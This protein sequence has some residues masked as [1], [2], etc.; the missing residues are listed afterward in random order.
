MCLFSVCQGCSVARRRES[1][2]HLFLRIWLPIRRKHP[3]PTLKGRVHIEPLPRYKHGAF[4]ED[5]KKLYELTGVKNQKLTFLFSESWCLRR[6]FVGCKP[7]C[8]Q[9]SG[10]TLFCRWTGASFELT[11]DF[12]FSSVWTSFRESVVSRLARRARCPFGLPLKLPSKIAFP[13]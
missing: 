9:Q 7:D 8:L 5:L 6:E 10:S 3:S 1:Y 11:Q 2:M 12:P 13:L 4:L